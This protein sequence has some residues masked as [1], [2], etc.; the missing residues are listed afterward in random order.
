MSLRND[1]LK[2]VKATGGATI[3][4][5]I[6][7]TGQTRRQLHNNLKAAVDDGLLTRAKDVVTGLPLYTITTKGHQRLAAGPEAKLF[8]EQRDAQPAVAKN[9]GSRESVPPVGQVSPPAEVAATETT[10]PGAGHDAPAVSNEL[11]FALGMIRKALGIDHDDSIGIVPTIEALIDRTKERSR[12]ADELL[13]AWNEWRN[14]ASVYGIGTPQEMFEGI[15]RRN[16]RIAELEE[17]LGHFA[18]N[19]TSTAADHSGD[20]TDMVNHPPHYQGKVECIDAIES[21][22]GPEGF[23]AYCRGNAIKYAFRAGKKG[24]AAQDL[25]KA[26]WYLARVAA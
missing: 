6:D 4:D 26:Q 18:E 19:S 5:I 11:K 14:I 21:A 17:L 8:H 10:T 23:A 12:A 13:D 22:L 25:A 1:I 2:Q 9:T 15:Q 24:D 3:D 16:H 7:A 20:A